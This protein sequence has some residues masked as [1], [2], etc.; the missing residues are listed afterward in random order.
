MFCVFFLYAKGIIRDEESVVRTKKFD[1]LLNPDRAMVSDEAR[2]KL[3]QARERLRRIVVIGKVGK[4]F[5]DEG[6]LFDA[7]VGKHPEWGPENS[8]VIFRDHKLLKDKP[9]AYVE[10]VQLSGLCYIHAPVILQHYL[11]AMFS[12]DAVPMLDMAVYL[13]KAHVCDLIPKNLKMYTK[14]QKSKQK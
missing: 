14:N 1:N 2:N 10:R 12:D 7:F 5:D 9:H 11:V 8:Y 3:K 6:T 4:N 13:K